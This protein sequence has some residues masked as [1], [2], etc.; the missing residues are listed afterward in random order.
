MIKYQFY[1]P[2]WFIDIGHSFIDID[3]YARFIEIDKWIIDIAKYAI[4]Y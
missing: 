1:L 3:N 2:N 4:K